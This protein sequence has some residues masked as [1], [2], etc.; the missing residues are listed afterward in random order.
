M[1][2]SEALRRIWGHD[3]EEE[4]QEEEAK[5]YGPPRP[6]PLDPSERIAALLRGDDPLGNDQERD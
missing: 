6:L 2:L 5:P 1:T 4:H 3:P